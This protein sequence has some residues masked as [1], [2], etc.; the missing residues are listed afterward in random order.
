[1]EPDLSLLFFRLISPYVLSLSLFQKSNTSP[2]VTW[3]HKE[4]N[5]LINSQV[6]CNYQM[7]WLKFKRR[8]FQYATLALAQPK[9]MLMFAFSRIHAIRYFM[10]FRSKRPLTINSQKEDS[11]FENLETDKVV[12]TLKKDGLYLGILIPQYL[13][14][15][16]LDFSKTA[17]Y[18]GN[19]ESQFYFSLDDKEKKE[20]KYGKNFRIGY[21]FEAGSLCPAVK[22]L[23]TDPK[24]WEIAS[25]YFESKPILVG[26]QIWWT[27]VNGA[28]AEGRAQGFYR[29]HYDLEDYA[30]LKFMF[31][32]TDVDL[33]SGPHLCVRGSHKK[34]KL[35]HQF[36]FIRETDDQDIMEYYGEEKVVTICEEAGFGFA[37][38]PFCFHKGV[39]PVNRN[40]LLLE[41]KF[42][43][44]NFG[45]I[46]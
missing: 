4:M 6:F 22:R 11:V 17:T 39:L 45:T 20:I 26:S 21:N 24:L 34:K 35:S 37:E 13:L 38:D 25:K 28:D 12:E 27:F 18:L 19:G 43:L 44:N 9:W 31:Y 14:Q 32:L 10:L 3:N 8:F 36:S 1:M 16:I 41:I 42:G 29:F 15:E 30:C 5:I 2:I 40:R 7:F 23:E 46:L 33:Y